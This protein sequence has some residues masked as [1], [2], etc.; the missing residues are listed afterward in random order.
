MNSFRLRPSAPQVARLTALS[1]A[2][3][4]A[5]A[6]ASTSSR[7]ALDYAFRFASAIVSDPKDM[8]KAQSAVVWDL[9]NSGAWRDAEAL[10]DKVEGWRRGATYAD[11]AAGLAR[12]GRSED[13][14]RMIA[15][16]EAF[17]P[18][19][20]GWQNLRIASHI[21]AAYAAMGETEKAR[22]LAVAVA[23][24][25]PQ[26]YGG[27]STATIASGLA[28]KGEL[29]GASAEL[30]RLKDAKDLDDPWW[31]T[32]GYVDMA[33]GKS[34]TR[35][36]RVN[37]LRSARE[38]ADG[39]PGWKKAEALESI[40]D[41]FR[42]IGMPNEA[43]EAVGSAQGILAALPDTTPIK[44]P[45]LSNCARAWAELGN[46]VVARSLLVEVESLAPKVQ[47]IE[48]PVVYA[49]AASSFAALK[50]IG[51]AKRLYGLALS[52]AASLVNARPRALAVVEICRSIGKSGVGLDESMRA[53]LD[54]LYAGLK[55]PW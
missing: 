14:K 2:L 54:A 18:T 16:A 45:L 5:H 52:D 10:A 36:Q 34:L 40:A 31:R 49:N 21:A 55:D 50:D 9:A 38:S 23:T 6:H 27:M 30:D 12:V 26:Q 20:D 29:S 41:E 37:A 1:L 17:R 25:D 3:V 47:D 15:K 44:A 53:R 22:T 35:E 39:I 46:V 8:G 48:R 42:K 4:L 11:L 32:V 43:K 33:R 7:D 19:I 28:A 51:E 24:E 13:A